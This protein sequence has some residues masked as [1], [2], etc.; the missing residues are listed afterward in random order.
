MFIVANRI[1]VA[2]DWTEEFE[3]KFAK[4]AG[5]IE[6]QPGFVRMQILRP[7]SEGTSYSVLTTWESEEAFK[8]WMGSP[9]FRIAHQDPMPREAFSGRPHMEQHLVVISAEK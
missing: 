6:T 5:E 4:R 2:E 9:D 8:T 7:V 1:P 3:R